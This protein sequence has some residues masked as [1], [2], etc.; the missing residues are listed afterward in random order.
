MSALGDRIRA[1]SAQLKQVEEQAPGAISSAIA[2]AHAAGAASAS[3]GVD[4]DAES[5][6]T[7]LEGQTGATV[8]SIQ[9]ALPVPPAPEPSPE[10]SV[11]LNPSSI[12]N[13]PEPDQ[14]QT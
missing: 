9:A 10:P 6:M 5:A 1:V 2:E 3:Q 7:E 4:A 12:V 13:A 8:Q 11:D 14:P